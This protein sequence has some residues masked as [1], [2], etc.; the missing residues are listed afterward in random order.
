MV[1][2]SAILFS[3]DDATP[4]TALTEWLA[5]QADVVL[6]IRH[7]DDLMAVSLRGRPRV[8]AFDA[9]TAPDVVYEACRRLKRD[10]Y[11]GVVPAVVLSGDADDAFDEAFR[12]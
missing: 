11:T 1:K 3:P 6:T 8:V 5:R 2:N 4:P 7:V 10:S 9:R 12:A